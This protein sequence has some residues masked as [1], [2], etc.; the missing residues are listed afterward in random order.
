[1]DEYHYT[2]DNYF[3]AILYAYM[4][5]L[6][7]SWPFRVSLIVRLDRFVDGGMRYNWGGWR[8]HLVTSLPH[9]PDKL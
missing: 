1:M 5:V 8:I 6:C 4:L 9:N 7:Y 3:C 2:M